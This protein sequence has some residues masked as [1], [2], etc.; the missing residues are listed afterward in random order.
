M[1]YL[2]DLTDYAVRPENHLKYEEE[3]NFCKCVLKFYFALFSPNLWAGIY[4]AREFYSGVYIAHC[5]MR[6]CG[7]SP[8]PL[9]KV[10]KWPE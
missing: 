7:P 10:L 3:K 1:P 8:L 5:A 4:K 2:Q 9:D 6:M